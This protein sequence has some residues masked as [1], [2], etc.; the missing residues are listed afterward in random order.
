MSRKCSS[1]QSNEQVVFN[2]YSEIFEK[3]IPMDGSVIFVFPNRKEVM[4]SYLEGYKDRHD[5]IPYED[6]L[7]VY[8]KNGEE[9]YFEN[10]HGPSELLIAE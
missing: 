5:N 9:M 8:D 6:I 3:K 10:I 1:L 2:L 7:A 4:V